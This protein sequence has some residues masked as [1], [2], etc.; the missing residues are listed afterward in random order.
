MGKDSLTKST[1]KK[2]TSSKKKKTAAAKKAAAVKWWE[3]GLLYCSILSAAVV[4]LFTFI[5]GL[6]R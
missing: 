5:W 3:Y 4:T 2:K 6:L 1:T